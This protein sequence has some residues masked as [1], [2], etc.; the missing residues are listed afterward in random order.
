MSIDRRAASPS[1]L[2]PYPELVGTAI[3]GAETKPATTPVTAASIPAT[4]T[5][6]RASCIVGS[7]SSSR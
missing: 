4:T 6:A 5:I 3:T 2:A 1:K 7:E